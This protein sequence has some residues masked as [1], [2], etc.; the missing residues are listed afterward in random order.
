[1]STT[2][3]T[4]DTK[5]TQKVHPIE[6]AMFGMTLM[7]VLGVLIYGFVPEGPLRIL[8]MTLFI[9]GFTYYIFNPFGTRITARKR[10]AQKSS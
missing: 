10:S 3:K 9:G 2:T 4:P 7:F 1:M 6:K 8:G 5:T